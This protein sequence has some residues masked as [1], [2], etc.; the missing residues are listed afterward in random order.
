MMTQCTFRTV[1]VFRSSAEAETN[2]IDTIAASM[3]V[4]NSD[5]LT[6]RPSH[7][8]YYKKQHYGYTLCI[9]AQTK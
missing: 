2:T 4:R 1:L 6:Q 7:C 5:M 3:I 9:L 8:T